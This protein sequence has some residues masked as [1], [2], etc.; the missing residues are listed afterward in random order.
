MPLVPHLVDT[1]V[2]IVGSGFSGLAMAIKCQEQNRDYVVFEKS[3][4]IGG[5]WRENTYP[6][7]ACDVP[8]HL[9]SFSFA[10]NPEWSR[11][12]A[13]QREI[14]AYLEKCADDFGVMPNVRLRTNVTR[15]MFDEE[16]GFWRLW[17]DGQ[18]EPFVARHLVFA[19]G[20][21][22]Q[23]GMPNIPGMD[24]FSGHAFHSAAW[25]HDV[26]LTG[27]KVAIIG[28][29][30]SAIQIAPQIADQVAELSIY[31]RTPPWIMPKPDR[32]ITDAERAS[33]RRSPL[34]QKLFRWKLYW[35][36][37]LRALGF[38]INP[39]I[40]K[41]AAKMGREHIANQI[42]DPELRQRVTPDYMP[43]CKRILLADDWYP[44][45]TKE[46]VELVTDSIAKIT[47]SSVVTAD[48]ASRDV[49]VIIYA[50]GFK[51]GDVLGRTE[52]LGKGGRALAEVWSDRISAYLGSAVSGFPNFHI[53]L[54]PNTGLGH[55]SMVF[56]AEAQVHYALSCMRALE[57]R[58]A[59]YMEVRPKEQVQF[60]DWLR[61]RLARSI[62]ATGCSS[63]YLDNNGHNF[64]A[65][66]GPTFEFWWRTRRV[67]ARHYDFVGKRRRRTRPWLVREPIGRASR[68]SMVAS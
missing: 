62:W 35:G 58:G 13:P 65:W 22:S 63:W 4:K 16:A 5:T 37:E 59:R 49:D 30:A 44:T 42:D 39:N 12:Y 26:D 2:A 18:G 11:L 54:G 28:T 23:P 57:R 31:Q 67:V 20:P 9:Y 38:T 43:G 21:L 45:L 68:P 24:Q 32:E 17:F 1:D 19:T 29:G 34:R 7:C 47:E 40:M 56:M 36:L 25:R 41:M 10:Q 64:S 46:N 52:V 48:G 33:F 51:V 27:K 55:N 15:C 60:N 3:T 6:G 61:P 8:A 14:Q 53:L 66:P 50:T